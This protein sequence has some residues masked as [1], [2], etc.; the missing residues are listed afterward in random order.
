VYVRKWE[1][2]LVEQQ[3]QQKELYFRFRDDVFLTTRLPPEK[4]ESIFQELNRSDPNISIQWEG[5]KSVDYL[6]VTTTI[7]IPNFRTNI[8]R[9][10]AAQPYILPFNLSHPLHIMKNI[11]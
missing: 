2:Q 11:P 4:I 7:D 9:K 3:Q 1:S 10:L 5:G 8:F 6:D